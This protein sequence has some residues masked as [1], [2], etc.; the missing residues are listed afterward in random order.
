MKKKELI[1]IHRTLALIREAA[2][3]EAS[4]DGTPN[5]EDLGV[6]PNG[7][8]NSKT[9]HKEAI[10]ELSGELADA[11]ADADGDIDLGAES[12]SQESPT[13]SKTPATTKTLRDEQ[14]PKTL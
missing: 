12:V 14:T 2:N 5:Y 6:Q 13:N 11:L 8:H 3:E 10:L 4:F 9:E 7:L 1:Q